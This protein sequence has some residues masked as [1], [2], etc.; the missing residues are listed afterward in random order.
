VFLFVHSS[1][2][3]GAVCVAVRLTIAIGCFGRII[4]SAG[5]SREMC[6]ALQ[7]VRGGL[8]GIGL[9]YREGLFRSWYC[10]NGFSTGVPFA[11]LALKNKLHKNL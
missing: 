1:K 8:G 2:R 4:A 10:E 6:F 9:K 5:L 3:C 11:S 7:A